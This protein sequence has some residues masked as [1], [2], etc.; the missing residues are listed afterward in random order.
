M[1]KDM[2]LHYIR[3]KEFRNSRIILQGKIDSQ[4][5]N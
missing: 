1:Q 4:D 3:Q 2:T 5:K